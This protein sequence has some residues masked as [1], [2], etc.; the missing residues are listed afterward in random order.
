M[1]ERTEETFDVVQL[2]G[3]DTHSATE[4]GAFTLA[5]NY[6][7]TVEAF[8]TYLK[9]LKPDGVLNLDPLDAAAR[10]P[11][12]HRVAAPLCPGMGGAPRGRDRGTRLPTSTF[13][14]PVSSP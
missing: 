6:L 7:Y 13:F 1:L 14:D 10:R 11:H 3:V 4:A 9:R 8:Q 5:E 12:A 2:S